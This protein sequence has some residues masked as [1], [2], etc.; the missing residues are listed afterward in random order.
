MERVFVLSSFIALYQCQIC[1]FRT[2]GSL[3]A[4]QR[5]ILCVGRELLNLQERQRFLSGDP[6]IAI[7]PLHVPQAFDPGQRGYCTEVKSKA[8]RKSEAPRAARTGR[9]GVQPPVMDQ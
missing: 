3:F 5:D 9:A 8:L 4:V 2:R 1:S 7:Q 6:G